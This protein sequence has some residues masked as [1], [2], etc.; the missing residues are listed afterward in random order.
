MVGTKYNYRLV[1]TMENGRSVKL[2]GSNCHELKSLAGTQFHLPKVKSVFV[3]D[4]LGNH[5]LYLVKG[6][7]EKTENVPSALAQF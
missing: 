6:K 5:F 2:A 1:I 7:P 3:G 4:I